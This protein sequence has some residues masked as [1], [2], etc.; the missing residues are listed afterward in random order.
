MIFGSGF[1]DVVRAHSVIVFFVIDYFK[2]G[3]KL[4][5]WDEVS[6]TVWC[7]VHFEDAFIRAGHLWAVRVCWGFLAPAILGKLFIC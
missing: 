7:V 6:V 2:L 1:G 4:A 5:F 3:I